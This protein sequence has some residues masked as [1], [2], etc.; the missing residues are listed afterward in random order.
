MN[1]GTDARPP[2]LTGAELY[3]AGLAAKKTSAL[4]VGHV[5]TEL[6]LEHLA[7]IRDVAAAAMN[8]KVAVRTVAEMDPREDRSSWRIVQAA[9]DREREA[10]RDLASYHVLGTPVFVDSLQPRLQEV[11]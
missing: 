10:V 5:L 3:G 11:A 7:S 9:E 6:D 1:G 2:A 4:T 8:V